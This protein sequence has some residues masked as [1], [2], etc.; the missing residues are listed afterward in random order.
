MASVKAYLAAGAVAGVLAGAPLAV[1]VVVTAV[2]EA[3]AVP[4]IAKEAGV[5]VE[6]ARILYKA[7]LFGAAVGVG[8]VMFISWLLAALLWRLLEPRVDLPRLLLFVT[9]GF[10]AAAVFLALAF[11]QA[12]PKD[13]AL[14]TAATLAASPVFQKLKE[15]WEKAK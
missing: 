3:E 10:L 7:V 6:K 8:F 12:E 4:K 11:F 13:V 5:S 9:P 2:P 15:R 14:I 1:V